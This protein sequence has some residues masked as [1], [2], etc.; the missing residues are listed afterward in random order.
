MLH[1]NGSNGMY[2]SVLIHLI[3]CDTIRTWQGTYII[4][5]SK[6]PSRMDYNFLYIISE[7]L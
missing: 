4:K 7:E 1:I 5:G 3:L 6:V 2:P